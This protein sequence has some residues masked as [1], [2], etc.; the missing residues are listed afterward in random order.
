M[1]RS[2]VHR[3]SGNI[4]HLLASQVTK[5][6]QIQIYSM[7]QTKHNTNEIQCLGQST[8]AYP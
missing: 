8:P 1:N 6:L 3:N 5:E 7:Q 4:S 2:L